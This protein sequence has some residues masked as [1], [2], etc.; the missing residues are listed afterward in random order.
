MSTNLSI[1]AK[2]VGKGIWES[3][4]RTV[5]SHKNSRSKKVP[6]PY[7]SALTFCFFLLIY[8][9]PFTSLISIKSKIADNIVPIIPITTIPTIIKSARQSSLP[10]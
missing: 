10:S 2:G 8:I 9:A 4:I 7:T 6:P 3:V 5:I 1:T